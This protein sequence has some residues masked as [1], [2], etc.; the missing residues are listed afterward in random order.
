M[1][2][3]SDKKEEIIKDIKDLFNLGNVKN[4][5][6][7]VKYNKITKDENEIEE[8]K[9]PNK[10]NLEEYVKVY[11]F[12]DDIYNGKII[13]NDENINKILGNNDLKYKLNINKIP[14][15]TLV[16]MILDAKNFD[17][18]IIDENIPI[19]KDILEKLIK[20]LDEECRKDNKNEKNVGECIGV[21]C[22]KGLI[23]NIETVLKYE[24]FNI[25]NIYEILI[26]RM[27]SK[28]DMDNMNNKE[29]AVQELKKMKNIL[30]KYKKAEP[31]IKSIILN[32]LQL[33]AQSNT[34]ELDIFIEYI[35]LPLANN[36]D[37]YNLSDESKEKIDNYL[38]ILGNSNPENFFTFNSLVYEE[39][40][41]IEKHLKH[42]YLKEKI[43]FNKFNKYFKENYIKNFYAKMQFY[44]G[45]EIQTKDGILKREEIDN[46]MKE[47]ILNISDYNKERYN[48]NDDIELILE[49]K[50][51][52]TLYINL[53]EIN[54]ENYYYQNQKEFY[55]NISLE[56][57]IPT[58]EDKLT[59]NEKPQLKKKKKISL[60]KITKKRGLFVIEFIGN[61]HVSRE[62]F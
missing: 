37:I 56:G 4:Y 10:L 41:I 48:I 54:T 55:T 27:Y 36:K 30:S 50:N 20:V 9:I 17:K 62:V 51:I 42:F 57:I 26:N 34:F 8:K 47:I 22:E 44:L 3:N 33:N 53:Y 12:V 16:K 59:F 58:F 23:E 61:G 11:Q 25:E 14:L 21:L 38:D 7:P 39:K 2:K 60:S 13:P 40:E 24:T 29:E 1:Q 46:L 31:Y 15:D 45:N 5:S 32:I 35:K 28:I 49:I 18:I 43:D 19:N 52:Q 6:K